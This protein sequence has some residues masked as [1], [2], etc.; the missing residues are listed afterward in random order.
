MVG[1]QGPRALPYVSALMRGAKIGPSAHFS[2]KHLED[3]ELSAGGGTTSNYTRNVYGDWGGN[4]QNRYVGVRFLIGGE[5]H[6]GGEAVGDYRA[7]RHHS[8]DHRLCIRDGG[9]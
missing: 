5:T 4:P 7:A 1:A 8:D 6:Y 9:E 2:S 3:I